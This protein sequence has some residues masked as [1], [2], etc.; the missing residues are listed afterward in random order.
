M[1][2]DL[3]ELAVKKINRFNQEQ[4]IIIEGTETEAPM[5]LRKTKNEG[6]E[7]VV[8]DL[9]SILTITV[10]ENT[11]MLYDEGAVIIISPGNY[12]YHGIC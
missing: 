1:L 10:T 2:R 6:K 8:E 4:Y 11:L 9:D 7:I 12:T 3:I 5:I